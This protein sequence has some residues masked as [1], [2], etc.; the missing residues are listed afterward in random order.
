MQSTP[1]SAI[2]PA[3]NAPPGGPWKK[4]AGESGADENRPVS[5]MPSIRGLLHEVRPLRAAVIASALSL[6]IVPPAHAGDCLCGT[7]ADEAVAA[8]AGWRPEWTVQLPFDA[9]RTRLVHVVASADLVVGQAE[10]GS[11]HAVALTGSRPGC[12]IWSW[13]RGADSLGLDFSPTGAAGVLPP[14]V[15]PDRVTV[16]LGRSV[17][18]LDAAT[19][20]QI[21]SYPFGSSIAATPV[22]SGKWLYTPTMDA[23]IVRAP[24]DP[25]LRDPAGSAE[26]GGSDQRPSK[27][28]DGKAPWEPLPLRAGG[29]VRTQ[30][31]PL[32]DGGVAWITE[33]GEVVALVPVA[34]GWSRSEYALGSPAVGEAVFRGNT[35]WLVTEERD[36]VRL[37]ADIGKSFR[38][39]RQWRVPLPA[40]AG[41]GMLLDGTT[42]VIPLGADGL[43]AYDTETGHL[44]WHVPCRCRLLALG[45]G[46]AWVIDA[47]GFLTALS[48]GDGM[49][50]GSTCLDGFSLPVRSTRPGRLFLASPQGLLTSL[51]PSPTEPAPAEAALPA[52][53]RRGGP[54]AEGPEAEGADPR[55]AAGPDAV[56]ADEPATSDPFGDRET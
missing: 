21:Y 5:R 51:V 20:R 40:A 1:A 11:V 53:A 15:G 50:I 19:G 13:P 49:P 26:P 7:L 54:E 23:S 18:G 42:L 6:A 10:D 31:H 55:P 47:A 46:R 12:R 22:E 30:P 27:R 37:E 28:S 38:I 4:S 44:R 32:G 43:A 9:G 3:S 39:R 8:Q 25:L 34:S 29:V 36:L 56:P 45:G 41:D 14:A 16:T 48:L 52:E 33:R 24:A 17:Y 35:V 2:P